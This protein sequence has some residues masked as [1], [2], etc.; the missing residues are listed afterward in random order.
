MVRKFEGQASARATKRNGRTKPIP[1]PQ[2][3][4]D[5]Y[6]D[7]QCLRQ[8]VRIAETGRIF[9]RELT[10]SLETDRSPPHHTRDDG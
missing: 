1:T 2:E 7:L 5:R 9:D 8:Q 3:L 4:A 6:F 10:G